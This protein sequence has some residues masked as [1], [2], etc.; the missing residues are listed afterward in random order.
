MLSRARRRARCSNGSRSNAAVSR[1]LGATLH[2]AMGAASRAAGERLGA[3]RSE[4]LPTRG[5]AGRYHRAVRGRQ[6][7]ACPCA[8]RRLARCAG[9]SDAR[10]AS[11]RHPR[12]H[13]SGP[14]DRIPHQDVELFD[15]TIADNIARLGKVDPAAVIVAARAAGL[16]ETIL[17]FPKG[18]V[19]RWAK[20]AR[21]CRAGSMAHWPR[22][23]AVRRTGAAGPR[24][25]GRESRPGAG[26]AALRRVLLQLK[27]EVQP[28]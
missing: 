23:S 14:A 7:H 11:R 2:G 17:Q 19:R 24:R 20:R 12:P 4:P 5:V 15:G 28:S 3:A 21:C 13:G 22:P 25:T 9:R 6:V 1:T 26:E 8:G 16:H 27:E 18:T 10:R